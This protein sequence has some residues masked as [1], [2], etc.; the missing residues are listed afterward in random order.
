MNLINFK[1]FIWLTSLLYINIIRIIFIYIK[2]KFRIY[3][4]YV[5]I[6]L[7]IDFPFKKNKNYKFLTRQNLKRKKKLLNKHLFK[8]QFHFE[9]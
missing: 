5:K 8:C 7:T 9:Q 4:L 1:S 2:N 3:L 6:K